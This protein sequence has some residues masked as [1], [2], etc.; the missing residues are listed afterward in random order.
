[1]PFPEVTGGKYQVPARGASLRPPCLLCLYEV[2]PRGDRQGR[3][4]TGFIPTIALVRVRIPIP[5]DFL[6]G[7]MPFRQTSFST[8]NSLPAQ[9]VQSML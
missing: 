1:V 3:G 6:P 8:R 9:L 2:N 7:P 5:E 4:E